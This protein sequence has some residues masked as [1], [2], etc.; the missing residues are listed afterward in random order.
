MNGKGCYVAD[1]EFS[2]LLAFSLHGALGEPNFHCQK[3]PNNSNIDE[4]KPNHVDP[5]QWQHYH[6]N[7]SSIILAREYTPGPNPAVRKAK[8]CMKGKV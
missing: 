3:S 4:I 8:V 2:F 7:P 1:A 6:L 5:A